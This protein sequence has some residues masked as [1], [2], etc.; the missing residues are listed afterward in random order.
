[1]LYGQAGVN[2]LGGGADTDQCFPG[3]A[4]GTGTGCE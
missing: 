2:S 3:G 4:G 1:M